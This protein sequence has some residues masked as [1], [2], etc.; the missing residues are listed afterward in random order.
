M[1]K[2]RSVLSK[3]PVTEDKLYVMIK[4]QL[5]QVIAQDMKDIA[6]VNNIT[7]KE[8]CEFV[9]VNGEALAHEM[10]I[11]RTQPVVY[12]VLSSGQ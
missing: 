9:S 1:A 7:L 12:Q 8:A 5:Q 4:P 2:A 6:S 3:A 10:H 11:S